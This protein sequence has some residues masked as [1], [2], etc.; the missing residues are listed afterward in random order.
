MRE[1][2]LENQELN[3]NNGNGAK[4]EQD[5]QLNFE[6]IPNN[7]EVKK[8]SPKSNNLVLGIVIG[9]IATLLGTKLMAGGGNN[10][11]PQPTTNNEV[12]EETVASISQTVTTTQVELTPVASSLS[13][14]GTVAAQELV[15]VMSQADGLQITEVLADEGDF[16]T[17]GQ[18]LLRL[19]DRILQSQL[20]QAQAQVRQA[21]AR[22]AE[23]KA[24]ARQEEIQRVKQRIKSAE[25]QV[26]QAKSDLQLAETR[27]SRNIQLQEEGAIAQDRLDEII[28]NKLVRES[29]LE[30]AEARLQEQKQQL[31]ELQAG[32]RPE[33][34]AQAEANLAQN[35]AQANLVKARLA[36][37]KVISP[38]SGKIA[39]RNARVGDVTSAFNSTKLFTVIENNNLELQLQFLDEIQH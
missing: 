23:L 22:L 5:S 35:E 20:K 28:N 11:Q 7:N 13:A 38:V 17:K 36:E 29:N 18:V 24:G 4:I 1:S 39:E 19:N 32:T 37:T 26:L 10:S 14:N 33:I 3:G 16:V 6:E 30:Q 21:Q 9:V 31:L 34:I 8:V 12:K 27:L 25:S 15:P 2:Q